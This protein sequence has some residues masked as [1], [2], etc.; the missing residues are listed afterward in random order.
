MATFQ[1]VTI[2]GKKYKQ[3]SESPIHWQGTTT[4][5]RVSDDIIWNSNP[6]NWN[7][8]TL[9]GELV[10]IVGYGSRY[11]GQR[12]RMFEEWLK[13]EP[14]KKKHLIRLICRIKGLKIYDETKD[15]TPDIKI[16]LKDAEMVIKEVLGSRVLTLEC[17]I[18]GKTYK[19]TKEV[20]NWH[21]V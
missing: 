17:D 10:E 9:A 2:G 11:S 21:G 8:V 18:D 20:G 6:Y 14:V 1:I 15:T 13:Q 19:Q 7:D 5:G 3:Y 12:R 16:T 4:D